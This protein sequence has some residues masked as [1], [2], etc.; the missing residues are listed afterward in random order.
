VPT[1]DFTEANRRQAAGAC[2]ANSFSRI[3]E[4]TRGN[5]LRSSRSSQNPP[6]H[7]D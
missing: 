5:K 2:S 7:Q 4:T 1:A 6:S 3:A